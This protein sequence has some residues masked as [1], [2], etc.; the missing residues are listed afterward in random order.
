MGNEQSSIRMTDEERAYWRQ[1]GYDDFGQK[2][3]PIDA[4]KAAK[5]ARLQQEQD[6]QVA[7]Q[8]ADADAAQRKAADDAEVKRASE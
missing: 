8:Q 3:R 4:A 1:K 2:C 6:A 7:E 5:R